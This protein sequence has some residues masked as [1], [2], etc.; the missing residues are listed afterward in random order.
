M[1]K[2]ISPTYQVL[3][4]NNPYIHFITTLTPTLR[5]KSLMVKKFFFQYSVPD[6]SVKCISTTYQVY[7]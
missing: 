2:C 7:V 5:Q 3:Y 4:V 6:L 1:V